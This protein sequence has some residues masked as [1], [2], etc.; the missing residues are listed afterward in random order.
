MLNKGKNI[1][2]NKKILWHCYKRIIDPKKT[3]SYIIIHDKK[4]SY[5]LY[6]EMEKS[7]Y[8]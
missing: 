8:T 7:L 6:D 4:S 5:L 3:I 1:Y 2:I